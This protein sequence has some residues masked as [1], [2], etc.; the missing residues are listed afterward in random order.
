MTFT[1][2]GCA[3]TPTVDPTAE[4]ADVGVVKTATPTSVTVGD[5]VTYTEVVSSDGPQTA[6][7]VRTERVEAEHGAAL[8]AS[9]GWLAVCPAR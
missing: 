9:A 2:L 1:T 3:A 4:S 5:L 8:V 7:N 6:F